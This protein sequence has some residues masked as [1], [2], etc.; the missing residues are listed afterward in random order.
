VK[1]KPLRRKSRDLE[2]TRQEILEVAFLEVYSH[3]FQG[4]SVDDIVAKTS[5][6]KG[7]FYHHFPTK[8]QLGYAIVEDVLQPMIHQRWIA[9]LAEYENPLEGIVRQMELLIGESTAAELH[10]GCPLNNLVQEM[11]RLDAGFRRRLQAAIALWI[12]GVELHIRR[13]QAAGFVARRVDAGQAA[14]FIVLMHEGIFGMLKGL[15]DPN[16]FPIFFAPVKEYLRSIE[17]RR[18]PRAGAK[19]VET[20]GHH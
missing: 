7:A 15:G 19:A 2:R 11:S 9:P 16:A 6:T 8:L 18:S 4:V 5:L 13:G 1:S 12:D 3:G 10:M 14:H 17:A 20:H